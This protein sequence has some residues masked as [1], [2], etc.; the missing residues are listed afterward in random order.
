MFSVIIPTRDRPAFLTEAVASVLEQDEPALEVLV[1]N[2]GERLAESFNSQR[3]RVI[4]NKRSGPVAA[5]RRGVEESR[6]E[7]IAFLDDDDRWSDARHLTLARDGFAHGADFCFSDGRL[8]FLS[9]EGGSDHRTPDISFSF[10]TTV[11][12]LETDNTILISAVSYRRSLHGKLGPFDPGLPFYWDWD[13]Y[14][15]VARAGSVMHHIKAPTVQIA[16]HD[17][18]M[19]GDSTIAERQANLAQLAA[20]HGLPPLQLKNHLSLALEKRPA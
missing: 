9:P 18:N 8:R 3:V 10:E 17:G 2:D 1:V 14:L 7:F 13:W 11:Q 20:K 16:V 4:D 19:S 5:R 15:R 12:S 6:G